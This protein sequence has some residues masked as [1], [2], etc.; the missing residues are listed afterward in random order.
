MYAL[1]NERAQKV[2]CCIHR[3]S[4]VKLSSVLI[5][6]FHN[7]N[8]KLFKKFLIIRI[9]QKGEFCIQ[10]QNLCDKKTRLLMIL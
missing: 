6:N 5:L 7:M 2:N 4:K 10:E 1:Y 9:L 8:N 3:W